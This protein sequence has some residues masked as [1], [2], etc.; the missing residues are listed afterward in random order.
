MVGIG[1]EVGPRDHV[2]HVAIDLSVEIARRSSNEPATLESDKLEGF[3]KQTPAGD[4]SWVRALVA[5][6]GNYVAADRIEGR[7]DLD[8]R[9]NSVQLTP[10]ILYGCVGRDD[11]EV[12]RKS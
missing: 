5:R 11:I 12:L 2:A 10:H 3:V 6:K 8:H 4:G 7:A 9:T 1:T